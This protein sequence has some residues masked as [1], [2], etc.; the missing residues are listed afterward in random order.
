[1]EH[2][3]EEVGHGHSLAAW[4]T[5]LIIIAAFAIGTLFFWLDVPEMVWAS[6]ALVVVGGLAGLYLR[7][8]GYGAGG[9]KTKTH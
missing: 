1:M 6:A 2:Q 5:V 8:A 3:N 4:V 9:S 7:R